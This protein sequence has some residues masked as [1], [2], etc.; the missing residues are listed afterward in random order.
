MALLKAQCSSFVGVQ[1][2]EL[3][4]RATLR[5]AGMVVAGFEVVVEGLCPRIGVAKPLRTSV[6]LSFPFC[7][8]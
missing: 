3:G 8:T 4:Y 6:S 7:L 2:G 5:V 1:R